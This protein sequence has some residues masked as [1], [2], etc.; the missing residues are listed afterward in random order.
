MAQMTV[1]DLPDEVYRLLKARAKSANRSLEAEVRTILT[2]A[3]R[4][5]AAED[6]IAWSR[7]F[8]AKQKL[9]KDWDSLA[10]IRAG[11]DRIRF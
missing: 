9:P 4:K 10:E 3:T 7:E 8:R 5:L 6:F 2:E 1:R 11:R